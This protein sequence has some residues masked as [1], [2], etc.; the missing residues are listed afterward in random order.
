MKESGGTLTR[1]NFLKGATF[2][3]LAAT[4]G[5]PSESFTQEQESAKFSKVVLIRHAEAMN[6][7]GVINDNVTDEMIKIAM[8]ELFQV[9]KAEQAWMHIFGPEDIVGIKSNVW[10]PL[11]TPSAV[12]NSIVGGLM[13]AGVKEEN[14]A[15]DDRGVLRNEVFKKASGYVNAR[16]MRTHHWSG[17]GGCLKNP[18]MFTPTPWSYH[19]NSCADLAKL[20]EIPILKDKIR[21]NILVMFTPL[22]HGVGA[23][24]F[25]EEYTWRY[26]GLIVGTDPVA[27]DSTGLSILNAKRREYYG[28]D[29]PIKPPPHHIVFAET[30]HKLGISDPT[31][32]DLI[33]LGWKENIL[34]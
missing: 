25:N 9:E 30:K 20:W 13:S 6:K 1:R 17:V 15:I 14:I 4:M 28:E 21:L 5:L 7:D 24:H 34:I 19:D 33:K 18:I 32:I 2:A 8:K 3:T 12:E 23:H 26:N 31:K 10:G 16:P 29:R 22:F 27:V 11:P